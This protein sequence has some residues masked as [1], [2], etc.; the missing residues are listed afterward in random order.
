MR[1]TLSFAVLHMSVAFSVVYLMTGNA[2]A[3][4]AVALIEPACNTVAY[5]FHEKV[6]ARRSARVGAGRP[7]MASGSI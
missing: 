3:G 5:H 1:K 4:G 2:M 7:A 6:W